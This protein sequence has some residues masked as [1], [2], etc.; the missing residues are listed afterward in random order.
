MLVGV[1]AAAAADTPASTFA[2]L[3]DTTDSTVRDA[4]ALA[5]VVDGHND[6]P[7]EIRENGEFSVEGLGS[8]N[9]HGKFQTDVPRLRRGGVGAQ[10]W[11]VHVPVR[12]QGDAAVR[13]ALVQID[14]VYRLL[15]RYP[16]DLLVA[17]TGDDVRTAWASG[18]I[19]S[20]V[21]AEGGHCLGDNPLPV[22][23]MFA[24]LGVRYLTLTHNT[25]TLWADSATDEPAH[26]GLT[27]TGRAVV[28][29]MN[30]LGVLVDLSHVS[31]TT[32]HD[33]LDVTTAPVIFSHSSARGVTDHPR[34]VPDDVLPRVTT[35]GGVV[36]IAFV[37]S[38]LSAD[39]AAW[40][41]GDR[42]GDPP[43]VTVDDLVRHVEHAR[44]LVGIDHIGLGGD[45][46]G[47]PAFPPGL[48]D[49]S[50][51]P[52]LLEALAARGWNA[53]DLSKLT[54]RNVLRVID[55]TSPAASAATT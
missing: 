52:R 36:M 13:S 38:F 37:P 23:R 18:R 51:Y 17:R 44:D 16:A 3:V 4:I 12:E 9:P 28:A 53:A 35:N 50:G 40:R 25:N 48:H 10:F 29:E 42:H 2:D 14:V 30:R 46:D 20:L 41:E 6:L 11:S 24:R 7:W 47:F 32:M 19:A 55:E 49:V 8:D 5:P 45:Y 34:N 43:P 27:D 31:P 22:L 21:G 54:G 15:A 39:Y 1:P 33:A 26:D